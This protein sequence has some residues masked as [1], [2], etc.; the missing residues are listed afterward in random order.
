MEKRFLNSKEAARYLSL[1]EPTIRNWVRFNKIPYS[2]LGRCVRFD[3]LKIN[4]WL[5]DKEVQEVK[6]II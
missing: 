1:T 3:M 6:D 5:K 4:Q 2:K